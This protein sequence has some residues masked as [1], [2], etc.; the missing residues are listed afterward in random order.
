[1][2]SYLTINPDMKAVF[3]RIEKSDRPIL[4]SA[5]TSSKD[6]LVVQLSTLVQGRAASWATVKD[7]GSDEQTRSVLDT[8]KAFRP[9]DENA[10]W[11]GVAL[12]ACSQDKL[13]G[14]VVLNLGT[15][16]LAKPLY[17]ELQLF[18]PIANALLTGAPG[19]ANP[20]SS[21]PN[22]GGSVGPGGSN[23]GGSFNPG[24][25]VPPM[26]MGGNPNPGG[27]IG[28]GGSVPPMPMGGNPNPGGSIGPG[29]SFNPGGTNPGGPQ[30]P[31]ALTLTQDK[32]LVEIDA[33]LLFSGEKNKNRADQEIGQLITRLKVGAESASSRSR[34]HELAAALQR[35]V[36]KNRHFPRGT[37][38]R[39]LT[40]ERF[41]EWGPDQRVSWMAEL[42]PY[43]GDSEFA[44]LPVDGEHGS[45]NEGNNLRFASVM[46][47]QYISHADPSAP[48]LI[49]Y[50]GVP[51][52]VAVTNY[53][54]VAGTG[55]DA[56]DYAPGNAKDG[57]F[58]YDRETKAEDV[59]KGTIVLLQIPAGKTPWM[60]GG[61]AT[62]R[63]VSEGADALQPFVGAEY[64]GRHG[65]FAVMGDFTVRF[66]PENTD[67]ARFV[68]MCTL[69]G[70]GKVDDLDTV[71]PVVPD[72]N[73]V[74]KAGGP[75]AGPPPAPPPPPPDKP[76]GAASTPAGWQLDQKC[77]EGWRFQR[78]DAAFEGRE[79]GKAVSLPS[80]KTPSRRADMTG[81]R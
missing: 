25:S 81:S 37:I 11:V 36:E 24:G 5:V 17:Q 19:G 69:A 54:G 31:P 68:T 28:P 32:A 80:A 16:D 10:C 49:H 18:V 38:K 63:G 70:G 23:P 59:K 47:P 29:G 20:G 77:V 53:V 74:L 79:V 72:D 3:D 44:N 76:A 9:Q 39:E 41:V 64:Q 71:A 65:T 78:L 6:P 58:G 13:S 34:I 56:A 26:P 73:P 35:Y 30:G 1:M 66:I 55:L 22:P 50:P 42:L 4:I 14:V 61:G 33:A 67:P 62:V 8:V 21:N 57:V 46:V 48:V 15:P 51:L 12:T 45:W 7:V 43:L 27:S 2:G 40:A 75:D 60:G 52:D